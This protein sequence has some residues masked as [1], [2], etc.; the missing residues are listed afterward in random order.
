MDKMKIFNRYLLVIIPFVVFNCFGLNGQSLLEK[1]GGIETDFIITSGSEVLKVDKQLLIRRA[2]SDYQIETLYDAGFGYGYMSF[3]LEFIA[4]QEVLKRNS[5]QKERKE[6]Y[7]LGFFD[8][9]GNLL[10]RKRLDSSD[11]KLISNAKQP[12]I[13]AYSINLKGVPLVLFDKV[14]KIDL[15]RHVNYARRK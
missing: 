2:V 4:P 7:L 15:V 12:A 10:V 13:F 6:Y 1:M 3:H 14:Q 5:F 11:V 9:E 8:K